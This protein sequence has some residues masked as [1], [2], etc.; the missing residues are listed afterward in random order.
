MRIPR[1]LGSSTGGHRIQ[2]VLAKNEILGPFEAPSR[3]RGYENVYEEN[4]LS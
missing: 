4:L 1:L 2:K 3:P